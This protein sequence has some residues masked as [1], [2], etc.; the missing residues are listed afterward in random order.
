MFT[1]DGDVLFRVSELAQDALAFMVRTPAFY[2]RELPADLTNDEKVA[3][4]AMLVEYKLLRI[5]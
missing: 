2:V 5:G 4:I 3:L 1:P